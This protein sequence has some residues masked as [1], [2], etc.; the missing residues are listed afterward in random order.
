MQGAYDRAK[1]VLTRHEPQLHKLA[2]E[3][4]DKETLSGEQI[5]TSLGLAARAA[6]SAAGQ[7]G[8]KRP[9]AA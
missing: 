9:E 8:G 2:A 7:V 5:R 1:A 3:L 6:A 4:L